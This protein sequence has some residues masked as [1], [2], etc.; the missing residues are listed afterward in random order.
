[1]NVNTLRTVAAACLLALVAGHALAK[2]VFISI[3]VRELTITE[4]EL[5]DEE[6]LMT[7]MYGFGGGEGP[8]VTLGGAG[9]AYLV[10]P[11]PGRMMRRPDGESRPAL[12]LVAR[13]PQGQAVSGRITFPKNYRGLEQKIVQFKAPDDTG[14]PADAEVQFQRAR[15]R[16][17]SDLAGRGLPGRTW[18]RRQ[19]ALARQERVRLKDADTTESREFDEMQ[20]MMRMDGRDDLEES[21]ELMTGGRAIE[22][23]LR[24]DREL[25]AADTKE[26][27]VSIAGVKGITI[28]P[29]AW[30]AVLSGT[31][32][33]LD[34]LASAI[35]ADQHALFFPSYQAM[36]DVMDEADRNG[37][38]I[39]DLVQSRSVDHMSR[40]RYQKQLCLSTDAL[41][42]LLG[43][44][45]VKS[46]AFTGSD[47]YL[48][49]GS[50][51]AVLF[52]AADPDALAALIVARQAAAAQ[53]DP[54]AK[55]I[56]GEIEGV[57][58]QGFRSPDRAVCSYLAAVGGVIVVSN[59]PFQ[60]GQ[61]VKAAQGKLPTLA[62]A[63]EYRFFRTRY[64]RG[65]ADESA[66]LILSD[67]TIR[68]WCGPK[69]RI[70]AMRR[71]RALEALA[72]LQARR[73]ERLAAGNA[74]TH[75]LTTAGV[76]WTGNGPISETWG[77]IAFATPIAE[78]DVTSATRAEIAAYDRFRD[79]YQREWSHYFDP[80]AVRFGVAPGR[81]SADLTVMPLVMDSDYREFSQLTSGARIKKGAGDPH[82]ESLLHFVMAINTKAPAFNQ[83][84][85]MLSGQIGSQMANPLG[86]LGSS[87]ALYAD[88]GAFWKEL[89]QAKETDDYFEKNLSR[90]PVA[91][92]FEVVDPLKLATFLTA[93]R[94]Y[95]DQSAPGLTRW[96]TL[97]HNGK[98]YV[99]ITAR[100][101]DEETSDSAWSIYYAATP[102]A[103]V[104]TLNEP[105]IK[106][107]L[108]RQGAKAASGA[109]TGSLGWQGQSV[110]LTA[111]S[112]ALDVAKTMLREP[113]QD[114]MRKAA[115]SNLP[116][117]NEWHRLF[118]DESPVAFH[119]RVAGCR[120]L[121]PAGGSYVWNAKDHTMESSVYGHPGRPKNGPESPAPLAS[122]RALA[123]GLTFE[124]DGLRAQASLDRAAQGATQK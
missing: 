90:I 78:L 56:S 99:Q 10:M 45:L 77:T 47:P 53:S 72:D 82:K 89:Q 2:D 32:P 108:E 66:L 103:L 93:I 114:A 91:A 92:N 70:A 80:I 24:L 31:S 6:S 13:V 8:I 25:Q 96:A 3:P 122:A 48:Q 62:A 38:P 23:N 106:R 40:D 97:E 104:V 110:A 88:E 34:P 74:S 22:E 101:D 43:P 98:P 1:M 116:I 41:S 52:E 20:Q 16:H 9:E 50:D 64:T 68:R 57:R 81:L 118:P 35:P 75:G 5:P 28:K 113:Y 15:E 29:Y 27:L 17:Y 33:A 12:T 30:D 46:V 65:D 67:N 36:A 59:S 49:G 105:L 14:R 71:A 39:L 83:F 26:P 86:W 19:A 55:P 69:W 73:I 121:D 115:W 7:Y 42:R 4:G 58:Y 87:I 100:G 21:Y 60:L 51:A 102:K 85:G 11:M 109:T 54:A 123:M 44:K 63:G 94:S 37:T 112:G 84:G 120:L 95:S 124:K 18:F 76:A 107:A 119:E 117:L 61:V 79:M 111:R